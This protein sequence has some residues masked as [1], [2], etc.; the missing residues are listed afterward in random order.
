M[1]TINQYVSRKKTKKTFTEQWGALLNGVIMPTIQR[2]YHRTLGEDIVS[3]QPMETPIGILNYIDFQ[4][5]VA[6]ESTFPFWKIKVI[7]NKKK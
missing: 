4:Y 1:R 6:S 7:F 2:V 3:V 5:G